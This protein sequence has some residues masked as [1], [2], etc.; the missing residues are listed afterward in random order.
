M[1]SR[2]GQMFRDIVAIELSTGMYAVIDVAHSIKHVPNHYNIKNEPIE[3][4]YML[5]AT[6][7]IIIPLHLKYMY[8]VAHYRVTY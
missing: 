6:P 5:T 2:C 7:H 4:T 1:H 3:Q 8:T